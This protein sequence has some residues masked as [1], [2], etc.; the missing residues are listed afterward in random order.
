MNE[1]SMSNAEMFPYG[2][3][4]AGLAK[5]VGMPTPGYVIWTTGLGLVDGTSARMPMSGV[6]RLDGSPME[7]QGNNRT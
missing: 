5:L 4:A 7:D 1:Q 6:Y 2:M 3:R